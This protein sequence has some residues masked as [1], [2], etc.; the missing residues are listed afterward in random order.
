MNRDLNEKLKNVYYTDRERNDTS[1]ASSSR[2]IKRMVIDVNKPLPY[3][4]NG[5]PVNIL[6]SLPNLDINYNLPYSPNRVTNEMTELLR[7]T[8]RLMEHYN[9]NNLINNNN[10]NKNYFQKLI[11]IFKKIFPQKNFIKPKIKYVVTHDSR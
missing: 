2:Y 3:T 6:N 5:T 8:D 1:H 4:T 10:F 11:S 9:D 7:R